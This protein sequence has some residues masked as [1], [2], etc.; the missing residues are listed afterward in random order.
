[1]ESKKTPLFK[2]HVKLG[3]KMADF[4]GWR[5]PLWYPTGQSEEH[6][7][8]RKYCGL[9]DI[10]H[11]GEFEI[12]GSGSIAFLQWL[13]T[14]DL[15]RLVDGQAMYN[16]MLNKEGGVVD[17]CITYRFDSDHWMLVVNAG[18]IEGDFQWLKTNAPA[19]VN[20]EN[21]SDQTVKID[22][23][24]PRAPKLMTKLMST[25]ILAG[26]KFFRFVSDVK[27]D[28]IKV[29]VSRTGYTGEIG[30]EIY[31]DLKN[32][33]DLWNLLLS[34]GSAYGI[35]PCGLGARDTLRTEAGLP[36]H[37]HELRPDR[38]AVG[39]P[40]EFA[41]SWDTDFIGK[42]VLLREKDKGLGYFVFPFVME[43]RR[44]AMP[45][46]EVLMGDEVIGTVLSGVISP[47]LNNT[48]IGF[49]GVNRSME[50]DTLLNF[51]QK[52]SNKGLQGKVVEIPFIPL[53][54]RKKM[55]NFLQD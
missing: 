23:Q 26:L 47:S 53:T 29:L 45:D 13:L 39:H 18:D 21:I 33:I 11:M 3:G 9:F 55:A 32:G 22:L 42:D 12:A 34:E 48:P 51:R 14:N 27:I 7:A 19:D 38:V 44:K 17:D 54:S 30:F 4:A 10:C 50:P 16:F 35:L 24:G 36:L 20:L 46:W 15:E 25:E 2:E 41:I 5:M 52:G 1:M 6:H 43:G 28:G 49:I 8:T 40:W 37:G 31:T